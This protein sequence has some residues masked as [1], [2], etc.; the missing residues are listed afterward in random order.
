MTDTNATFTELDAATAWARTYNTPR[1]VAHRAAAGRTTSTTPRSGCSSEIENRAD[2]L[3]Y[4]T[5]K[6]EAIRKSGSVVRAELA[7]TR[8][9]PMYPNPPR[10]CVVAE[11]DGEGAATILFEVDGNRIKR[12]DMCMIPPPDTCVR[13][14]VCPGLVSAPGRKE[15]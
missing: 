9:Y 11:Q 7:E 10:P 15:A 13:S 5:A 3:D 14:G 4:L 6:L 12:I 2:Y 1:R 8:P